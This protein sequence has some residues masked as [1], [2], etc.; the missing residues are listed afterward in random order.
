M[1]EDEQAF[2]VFWKA[3]KKNTLNIRVLEG[4]TDPAS[5]VVAKAIKEIAELAFN[6][7]VEWAR[8][9]EK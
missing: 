7:G 8:M 4:R 3:L 1:T 5:C 9:G 6:G 2:E